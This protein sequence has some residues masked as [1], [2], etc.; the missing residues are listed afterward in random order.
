LTA[1]TPFISEQLNDCHD[2]SRFDCGRPDINDGLRNKAL[3]ARA[4]GT[5]RTFVWVDES[6]AVVAGYYSVAPHL[7][8]RAETPSAVGRGS[9]DQIPA[10]LLA[11]LALG[12]EYQGRGLGAQLLVDALELI[13]VNARR[14]G[15][16]LVVVDA[17]DNRARAFYEHHGFD[18][19]PNRDDRV[20]QELSRVAATLGLAWP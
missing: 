2:L 16:R 1:S 5:A 9:P 7:I 4:M 11:R 10:L 6:V 3:H 18:G 19:L 13:V 17:I 15:G 20:V 8:E 14:V 12:R